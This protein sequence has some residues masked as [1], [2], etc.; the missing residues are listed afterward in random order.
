MFS[1]FIKEII[2]S[3]P[4]EIPLFFFNIGLKMIPLSIAG[5]IF[6]LVPTLQFLTSVFFLG[7]KISL[8]KIISFIIIWIAVIVF[9][10]ESIK[11]KKILI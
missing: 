11:T 7:E 6:Y 9:L 3:L 10:Y 4:K 2:Y 1:D 5:L 8:L